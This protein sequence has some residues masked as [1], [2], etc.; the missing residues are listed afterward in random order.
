[1]VDFEVGAVDGVRGLLRRVRGAVFI[2]DADGTIVAWSPEA[3]ARLGHAEAAALGRRCGDLLGCDG[4]RS[5]AVDGPL[6]GP[7]HAGR[8]PAPQALAL[9]RADG[10]R[11]RALVGCTVLVTPVPGRPWLLVQLHEP[12]PAAG[13]AARGEGPALSRREREVLAL[14]AHGAR[15]EEIAARLGIARATVRNHVQRMFRK[16][17]VRSRVEAVARAYRDGLV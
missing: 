1:M 16:L 7:V 8:V 2:A 10:A 12:G 14:L 17:D 13:P 9:R 5:W 15:G 3:A 6:L 4:D 11:L